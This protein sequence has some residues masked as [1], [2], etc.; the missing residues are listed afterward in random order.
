MDPFCG[1]IIE[2]IFPKMNGL[3]HIKFQNFPG[4]IP[5]TTIAGGATPSRTHFQH[6]GREH[7][8]APIQLEQGASCSSPCVKG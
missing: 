4:V 1:P 8:S 7:K 3:A 2:Q 5:R 6:V